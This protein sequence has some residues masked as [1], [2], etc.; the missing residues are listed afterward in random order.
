MHLHLIKLFFIGNLGLSSVSKYPFITSPGPYSSTIQKR[1]GLPYFDQRGSHF[2]LS[3]IRN[4]I[5]QRLPAPH[6]IAPFNENDIVYLLLMMGSQRDNWEVRISQWKTSE[7]WFHT[8]LWIQM[9]RFSS[10]A[11]QTNNAIT[12]RMTL[13]GIFF[14]G[15]FWKSSVCSYLGKKSSPTINYDYQ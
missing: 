15:G 3:N 12:F 5:I 14:L 11:D 1:K 2:I 6:D 9:D 4:D 7:L 8:S 10:F 13:N